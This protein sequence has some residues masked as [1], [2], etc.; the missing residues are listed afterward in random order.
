MGSTDFQK[1]THFLSNKNNNMH[2]LKEFLD[3]LVPNENVAVGGLSSVRRDFMQYVNGFA[4]KPV[5]FYA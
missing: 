1:Q 5:Y 3:D 4:A 2:G